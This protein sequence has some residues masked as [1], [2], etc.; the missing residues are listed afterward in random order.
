MRRIA[1]AITAL[2]TLAAVAGSMAVR[3]GR[4]GAQSPAASPPSRIAYI[5]RGHLYVVGIGEPRR[6]ITFRGLVQDPAWSRD[7]R[8]L[9]YRL[10]P[11]TS[12]SS[13]QEW[14]IRADGSGAHRIAAPPCPVCLSPDGSRTVTSTR[15]WILPP[16]GQGDGQAT[17]PSIAIVDRATG[18]V[19]RRYWLPWARGENVDVQGWWPDGRAFLFQLDPMNS[20]SFAAD[21][22]MLYSLTL[23]NGR[24][25][26]LAG[27]LAYPDW[28]SIHGK[29]A[30]IVAGY[31]RDAYDNKRVAICGEA[32][33]CRTIAGGK[34]SVALDPAW[35]PAGNAIAWVQSPAH[36]GLI[37]PG[38]AR[39]YRQWEAARTLWGALPD[40]TQAGRPGGIPGGVADPQWTRDGRGLLFVQD[41]ALWFDVHVGAANPYLVARLFPSGQVPQV[42]A[43]WDDLAYYGHV[44]WEHL[45]AWWQP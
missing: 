31:G 20:A 37:G 9:T 25:H 18:G 6:Q 34:G 27:T 41:N 42:G 30:L 13:F 11:S 22:L 39:V 45:F 35:S 40:G 28:I 43:Y 33:G 32:G 26:A 8:S 4:V 10:Q 2:A 7:G 16:H 14:T 19:V 1:L 15:G 21:G 3:P 38:S 44:Q 17:I 12:S 5:W 23:A 29:R 24:V 36:P